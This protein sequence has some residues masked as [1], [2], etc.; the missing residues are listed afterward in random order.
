MWVTNSS[1]GGNG[2][3]EEFNAEIH[4]FRLAVVMLRDKSS[5]SL[6]YP[7]AVLIWVELAWVIT[8]A[9]GKPVTFLWYSD[10]YLKSAQKWM[11]HWVSVWR[12]RFYCL[13]I[14]LVL[15]KKLESNPVCTGL[16][17]LGNLGSG[18]AESCAISA[19]QTSGEKRA[20]LLSLF[21]LLLQDIWHEESIVIQVHPQWQIHSLP[22]LCSEKSHFKL[23]SDVSKHSVAPLVIFSRDSQQCRSW[24]LPCKP[25]ESS[26]ARLCC[27]KQELLL[28]Q[29]KDLF[30]ESSCGFCSITGAWRNVFQSYALKLMLSNKPVLFRVYFSVHWVGSSVDAGS[31]KVNI[32]VFGLLW[33]IKGTWV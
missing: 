9:G 30:S 10:V 11:T 21:A 27:A 2:V 1:V 23:W 18:V 8:S 20:Y 12:S 19:G 22:A 31:R 29:P 4:T 25:G 7:G 13:H 28:I 6:G 26:P 14:Q 33:S 32:S 15:C 17:A 16:S 24:C 5:L 3:L